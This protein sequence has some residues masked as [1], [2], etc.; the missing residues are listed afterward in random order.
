MNKS[1]GTISGNHRNIKGKSHCY[2]GGFCRA[3]F[4]F[5][6]NHQKGLKYPVG[7]GQDR[8]CPWRGPPLQG[9]RETASPSS[10]RRRAPQGKAEAG[11]RGGKAD[12]EG[13]T[14]IIEST[15]R[16]QNL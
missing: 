2:G 14:L 6:G 16:R 9:I 10:S 12:T 1:R 5:Y 13:D 3:S 15:L 7:T 8:P 4:R 11:E